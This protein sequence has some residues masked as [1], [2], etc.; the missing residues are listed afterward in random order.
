MNRLTYNKSVLNEQKKLLQ[1]YQRYLPALE[2]KQRKLMAEKASDQYKLGQIRDAI[3]ALESDVHRQLPML[4]C[5][6]FGF[7]PLV[8]IDKVSISEVNNTGVKLPILAEV[9]VSEIAY[10]FLVRPH[11]VDNVVEKVKAAIQLELE[12]QVAHERVNRLTK[13]T[14]TATQRVNLFSKFL[15]PEKEKAIRKIS[16]YLDD[17]QS[18][19]VIRAKMTKQKPKAGAQHGYS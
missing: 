4:G 15:I 19:A 10:G 1:S 11:W 18:A 12:L 16:I 3:E 5:D 7:G 14:K 8:K 6:D 17:A 9:S 13:A 2:L